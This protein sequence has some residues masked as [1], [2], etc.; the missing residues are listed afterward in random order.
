MRWQTDDNEPPQGFPAA[1]TRYEIN[2][3]DTYVVLGEWPVPGVG[4]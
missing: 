2:V 1:N 3:D 4:A